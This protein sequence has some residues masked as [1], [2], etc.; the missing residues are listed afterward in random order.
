MPITFRQLHPAFAAEVSGID[1]REALNRDQVAAVEAGM[2]QYAVLV[3]RDQAITDDQQLA[4]T[5]HF[6]ALENYRSRG[7]I[8]KREESRLRPGMADFS[9]LDRNGAI[10]SADDRVWFF[11]LGDRLWHSDSSFRPIP[12]RYSLLSGRVL[13]SW[14]ANTEF[15]DMRAAYDALDGRTRAEVEDLVCEHSLIYSR[16]AIG[17]TELTAEE[18]AAF[19]PVRQRLVRTHPVTGRRS[20]FLSSHAGTIVGWTIPE[21]RMF[22]RDLTEFAT[23][24]EFVYSHAWRPNDLVMWDNRQTMHR[25]RR[26]DRNEVRDVRRTTLAGDVA[27]IEQAAAVG[28]QAAEETAASAE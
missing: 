1:C 18:R 11:K 23:Q 16:E 25:G 22:L 14:G 4:F 9:N 27:T 13:P 8:Q 26:Y 28:E 12:A 5:R 6:G 19:T 20:L 24:R 15:A 2:D 21:A 17:F 10:I 7:H 3:F